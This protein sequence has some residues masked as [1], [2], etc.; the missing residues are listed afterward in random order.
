MK[1][2][3]VQRAKVL[4]SEFLFRSRAG[5]KLIVHLKKTSHKIS[6]SAAGLQK[7]KM[8]SF[9][10]VLSELIV[11]KCILF[12]LCSKMHSESHLELDT[13]NAICSKTAMKEIKVTWKENCLPHWHCSANFYLK[14]KQNKKPTSTT[15]L[16]EPLPNLIILLSIIKKQNRTKK[17]LF[18]S[19]VQ[20]VSSS[21]F[22]KYH[23]LM[24]CDAE[25]WG[26]I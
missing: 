3:F 13:V 21:S 6:A 20:I 11:A 22:S 2:C 9:I 18:P 4:C 7:V 17:H 23:V 25:S 12:G 8:Q 15:E 14:T 26:S 1:N 10:C 16:S 19:N 5:T 24:A